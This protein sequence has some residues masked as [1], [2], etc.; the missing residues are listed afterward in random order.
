MA[1]FATIAFIGL[2]LTSTTP[3]QAAP[4]LT[5][6]IYTTDSTCTGVN[7]N[8]YASKEDVYLDGGPRG[9]SGS[10]LPDGIY[11]VQVTEP[12]GAVLGK[13]LAP[14]VTVVG[15]VSPPATN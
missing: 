15:A 13:S 9:A 1:K 8:I 7:V 11:Y 12:G 2:S 5:G 14:V 4:P 6:A 3:L 10:G